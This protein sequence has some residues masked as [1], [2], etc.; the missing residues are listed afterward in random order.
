VQIKTIVI[1]ASTA[2]VASL[3][4]AG[5]AYMFAEHKAQGRIMEV[6][7]IATS[8]KDELLGYT[9][10]TDY[11]TAGKQVM[12][13]QAKF[14]AA[15][16][17]QE[18]DLIEHIKAGQLGL[19]SNATVI[20]HYSVEYSFGYELKPSNF[21]VRAVPTGIEL[22]IGRPIMVASPAV[23]P[24]RH[25]IP[26]IGLLTDEKGAIIS[27]QQRLPAVAQA[28]GH[29]MAQEEPIRAICEKKLVEFLRDFLGKQPGVKHV[30]AITVV[31]K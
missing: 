11:I 4:G 17:V 31:Y 2:L 16:V 10:Y 20:V 13:E 14:L 7:A 22:R 26:S 25:E 30:P 27:I 29:A 18:Y 12:S 3:L 1:V 28:K 15:K 9:K 21:D 5:G 23:T 6:E 19:T 24:I 8:V